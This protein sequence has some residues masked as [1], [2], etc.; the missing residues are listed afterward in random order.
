[1]SLATVAAK[2][3]G[4]FLGVTKTQASSDRGD[5]YMIET[6]EGIQSPL[7]RQSIETYRRLD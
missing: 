7:A 5:A 6:D 1:M 2:G 3:R 4:F